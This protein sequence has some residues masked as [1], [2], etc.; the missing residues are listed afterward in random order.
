MTT[1]ENSFGSQRGSSF[2]LKMFLLHTYI[3]RLYYHE[4]LLLVFALYITVAVRG[5]IM[6]DI[7]QTFNKAFFRGLRDTSEAG[8][9]SGALIV[10]HNYEAE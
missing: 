4:E 8:R 7:V 6:L 10:A 3:Y 5:P 1:K 2:F 9:Q